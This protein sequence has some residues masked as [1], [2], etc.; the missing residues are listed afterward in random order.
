MDEK[1]EAIE[2]KPSSTPSYQYLWNKF[3]PATT[4]PLHHLISLTSLDEQYP[5][6]P[7]H[8]LNT[9]RTNLLLKRLCQTITSYPLLRWMSSAPL[10]HA[11]LSII[12]KKIF[13]Q[14]KCQKI[15][16]YPSLC[17]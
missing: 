6:P 3:T 12:V 7:H 14:Q 13:L 1:K 11:I 8:A 15:T 5:T 16:S 9:C 4:M 17:L 10:L 2:E